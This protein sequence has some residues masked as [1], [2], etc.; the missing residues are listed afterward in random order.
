[1]SRRAG[2]RGVKLVSPRGEV[3]ID[4]SPVSRSYCRGFR[5]AS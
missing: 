5:S 4:P 3:N 1:L 2:S